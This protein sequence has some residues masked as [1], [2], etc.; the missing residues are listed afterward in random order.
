MCIFYLAVLHGTWTKQI[1]SFQTSIKYITFSQGMFF[2]WHNFFPL[3]LLST[4]SKLPVKATIYWIVLC[5]LVKH[6]VFNYLVKSTEA[7]MK[8]LNVLRIYEPILDHM[9]TNLIWKHMLWKCTKHLYRALPIFILPLLW[10]MNLVSQPSFD[11][12]FLKEEQYVCPW[13]L[14]QS[15][16]SWGSLHIFFFFK[17]K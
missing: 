13:Q 15:D 11:L 9:Q 1:V 8:I 4:Q 14:I 2:H 7:I 3:L 16:F 6:Y 5:N 12:G 10:K 17:I